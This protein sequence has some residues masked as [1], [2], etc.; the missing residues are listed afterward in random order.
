MEPFTLP[1]IISNKLNFRY[2]QQQRQ[3]AR[4]ILHPTR[5]REAKQASIAGAWTHEEDQLL[6]KLAKDTPN[7]KHW[8]AMSSYFKGKTPQQVMNRWN[9]VINPS[10][11][12]GNWSQ[13]EDDILTQWVHDHGEKGWTKVAS[14]LKGRIGKQCRERW[15]NCLKPGISKAEWTKAEDDTIILLQSTYGN[16]WAMIAEIIGGRTDNQIKNRWNSVLK[17]RIS[18]QK[19]DLGLNEPDFSNDSFL[20]NPFLESL[21]EEKDDIFEILG[22]IW[23]DE[24]W[25]E[26]DR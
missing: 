16:K 10:L 7:R 22:N 23:Q 13:E 2:Q 20:S 26:K 9:K 11:V 19:D 15:V 18:P 3:Q 25:M 4:Q 24:N 21:N 8:Q 6:L 1:L 14:K 17:K 12:K 5:K